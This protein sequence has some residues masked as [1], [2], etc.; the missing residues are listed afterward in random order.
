MAG[1]LSQFSA[2]NGGCAMNARKV[3]C[4]RGVRREMEKMIAERSDTK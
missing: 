1:R 3:C 4:G 2:L